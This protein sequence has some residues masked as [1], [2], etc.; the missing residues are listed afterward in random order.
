MSRQHL[1]IAPPLHLQHLQHANSARSSLAL[2]ET[3]DET[4]DHESS[5][6]GPTLA[7][8]ATLNPKP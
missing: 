1:N 8:R 3:S 5:V 7:G 6:L 2:S 4:I